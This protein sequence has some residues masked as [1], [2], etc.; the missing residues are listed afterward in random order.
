M[1]FFLCLSLSWL[2]R[3]KSTVF[4][5][6]L[7]QE[8]LLCFLHP[9]FTM[10]LNKTFVCTAFLL[11]ALTQFSLS[12][13]QKDVRKRMTGT[14]ASTVLEDVPVATSAIGDIT[15]S[16]W[17]HPFGLDWFQRQAHC[18]PAPSNSSGSSPLEV[19][20]PVAPVAPH[21]HNHT[22]EFRRMISRRPLI[23]ASPDIWLHLWLITW[24]AQRQP[25]EHRPKPYT[26]AATHPGPMDELLPAI[27]PL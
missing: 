17:Q 8:S 4:A 22:S 20:P 27:S 1:C 23:S 24:L 13:K 10:T 18:M 15:I 7:F 14:L 25:I 26:I 21:D 19:I 5:I 12:G 6:V 2:L 16:A 11:R 9:L 3:L